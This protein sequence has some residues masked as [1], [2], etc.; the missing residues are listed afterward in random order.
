M[1]RRR[2]FFRNLPHLVQLLGQLGRQRALFHDIQILLQLRHAGRAQD[3]TVPIFRA[4][5]R[6]MQDP[7]QGDGV[8]VEA[9]RFGACLHLRGCFEQLVFEV[10]VL[11]DLTEMGLGSDGDGF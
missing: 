6:M 4:Q 8:T 2:H 11:I 1:I 5:V 3:D 7:S 9:C 10:I